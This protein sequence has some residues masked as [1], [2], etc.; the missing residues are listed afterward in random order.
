MSNG[1]KTFTAGEKIAA[2]DTNANN[3]YL[4]SLI[5]SSAADLQTYL[6][7]EFARLEG[8]LSSNI[9]KPGFIIPYP[10]DAIP[11]GYLKCDGSSLLRTDYSDLFDA[12]GTVYG[13]VDDYHFNLPDLQGMFLRGFGGN[14]ASIG[15]K[16]NGGVPDHTHSYTALSR[17]GADG[18]GGNFAWWCRGDSGGGYATA[19]FTMASA[20]SAIYQ[21]GLNEV[22]PDNFAV[23]WIIKY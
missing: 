10:A 17:Y 5:S 14:S 6:Q 11:T 13:A 22:R 4:E 19:S 18:S 16:Q 3:Q 7:Q 1:L 20:S 2:V 15:T 9:V 23:H 8:L 21:S 12:I